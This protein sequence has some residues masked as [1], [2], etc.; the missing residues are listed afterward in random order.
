MKSTIRIE[1][2]TDRL[3]SYHDGYVASLWHVAQANPVE[4]GDAIASQLVGAIST[5]IVRRFLAA[6]AAPL[7]DIQ[8]VDVYRKGLHGQV[9]A[10]GD[11]AAADPD[12]TVAAEVLVE[13]EA[14]AP[15]VVNAPGM[16]SV[17]ARTL[18]NGLHVPA[19]QYSQYPCSKS[20]AG[21]PVL[22]MD[23]K[24]WVNI[25]YH[26]AVKV[27]QEAGYTLSRESQELSIRLE[28]CEQPE[29]WT[30]G[31]VGVGSVY[32]GLHKGTVSGAKPAS[33]ESTDP[34]ERQWHVLANGQ[35]VYGL[36]GNI[37]NWVFD[38][39][40]G[41]ARG[42][43]AGEISRDSPS[44]TT[45][46]HPSNQAGMGWR[47]EGGVN[48]SGHALVRGGYWYSEDDAGVFRLDSGWPDHARGYVGFRYT[49]P[50]L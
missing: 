27:C 2:D 28:V 1:I 24:P 42:L 41:D 13:T 48:W 15:A 31:A 25:N 44:L 36:A 39:I 16:V 33:Y 29:N 47:P 43:V 40:Q 11:G 49:A 18:S 20:A 17:A 30:G 7:Y 26:D 19:F 8:A 9:A 46:P 32:L 38:D 23:L 45:P 50:G 37:F 4:Y 14:A 6:Q 3:P 34:E 5:E 35:R 12:Q 22:D 10:Q 21:T